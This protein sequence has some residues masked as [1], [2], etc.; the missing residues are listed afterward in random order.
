MSFLDKITGNKSRGI[1]ASATFRITQEGREKLQDF[2]GDPKSR[3]LMS[4][5]T[6]GS[7]TVEEMAARSGLGKGQVERMLPILVQGDYVQFISRR[8]AEDG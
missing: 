8:A 3:I 7:S 4:L 5:E 1:P 2:S 6:G